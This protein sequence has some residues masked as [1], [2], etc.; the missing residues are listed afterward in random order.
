MRL[1]PILDLWLVN[2]RRRR[3]VRA[4]ELISHAE[5]A[6]RPDR[7]S[8]SQAIGRRFGGIDRHLKGEPA[9]LPDG[10]AEQFPEVMFET[11]RP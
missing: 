8:L 11:R 2:D 1:E 6:R 9:G 5:G 7:R 10:P 3:D 4:L